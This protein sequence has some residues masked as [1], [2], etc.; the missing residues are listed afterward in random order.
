MKKNIVFYSEVLSLLALPEIEG[1]HMKRILSFLFILLL[2]GCATSGFTEF[3]GS[4]KIKGGPSD[5]EAKCRGWDME[6]VG[7][8]A[9]GEYTDG[10]ICKKKGS[11]LS[12][13]DVGE[14]IILSSGVPGGGAVAVIEMRRELEA[15][16]S[17]V[18]LPFEVVPFFR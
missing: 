13:Q 8:V 7:M 3:R 5:C 11:Q 1:I 9:L 10:C 15:E 18:P 6:L 14:A 2:T 16:A 4:A 17:I 12:M